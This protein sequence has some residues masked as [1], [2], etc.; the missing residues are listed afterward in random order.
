MNAFRPL[1]LWNRLRSTY[2]FLPA[3]VTAACIGAGLLLTAIDRANP[4]ATDWL[5]AAYGGGAAGAR[6]LLSA[7]AGSTI[8]VVSVTF[9]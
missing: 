9:S 8:T 7:V 1:A 3:L 2:W 6:A 5:G 4:N